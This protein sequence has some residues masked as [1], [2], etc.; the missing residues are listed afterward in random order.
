MNHEPAALDRRAAQA[1]PRPP[2]RLKLDELTSDDLDHLHDRLDKLAQTIA[3]FPDA[4][5][6]ANL[7][8][9]RAQRD[10]FLARAQRAEAA[11]ERVRAECERITQLPPV[12]TNSGRGDSFDCGAR[13]TIRMIRG[14]LDQPAPESG[15]A[16]T[17][18]TDT[19]KTARVFAALHRSAEQD[20]TR[21]I[22]LYERWIKAGPP[23]GK[24]M[25]GYF[26]WWHEHLAELHDAIL[27]PA[28]QQPA[29]AWTPPPPGSTR[30][31]V[32]LSTGC[33]HGDHDYC[34]S[35]TGL[36]GAKRPGECK[37]CRA[38]C[39]CGCH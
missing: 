13:W 17:Q 1:Q 11:L 36:N 34:Q 19:E 30:E 33:W 2:A 8:H 5:D 31:H 18:A 24:S 20:V 38:R 4:N 35:M 10:T 14:A 12:A 6:A 15:P 23:L 37:K 39:I 28:T 27:N 16:A 9:A 22:D 7:A 26:Q 21:V 29:A 32:Y 3:A 25:T